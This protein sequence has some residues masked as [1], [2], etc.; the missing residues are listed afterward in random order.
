MEETG[1]VAASSAVGGPTELPA[2]VIKQLAAQKHVSID[3]LHA[4]VNLVIF[5]PHPSALDNAGDEPP[6]TD[7]WRPG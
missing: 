4:T 3:R 2:S 6:A 7:G 1:H 5:R